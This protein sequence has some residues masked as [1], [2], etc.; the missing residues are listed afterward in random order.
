MI[1]GKIPTKAALKFEP[2]DNSYVIDTDYVFVLT[3]PKLED[4]AKIPF[5]CG[6]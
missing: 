1:H 5:V 6:L 4:E 2:D 3:H